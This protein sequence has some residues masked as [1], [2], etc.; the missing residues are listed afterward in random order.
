MASLRGIPYV[1]APLTGVS[2]RGDSQVT[3][4]IKLTTV[5]KVAWGFP[6]HL[7]L[8]KNT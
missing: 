5:T 1:I 4:E 3:I 6:T 2:P 7:L 8:H